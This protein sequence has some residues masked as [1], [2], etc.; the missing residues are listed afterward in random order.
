MFIHVNKYRKKELKAKQPQYQSDPNNNILLTLEA[1][2]AA[3]YEF[4]RTERLLN[5]NFG[6]PLKL[7]YFASLCINNQKVRI[8]EP[9]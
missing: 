6:V 9:T 2:S 7:A 4:E 8:Y 3:C 1:F 5:V